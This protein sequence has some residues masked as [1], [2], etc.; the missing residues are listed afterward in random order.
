MILMIFNFLSLIQKY[1]KI[2][3]IVRREAEREEERI[4]K[5]TIHTRAPEYLETVLMICPGP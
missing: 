4:A 1:K 2:K 5:A 3:K